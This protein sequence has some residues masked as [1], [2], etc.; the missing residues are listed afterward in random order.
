ML[1]HTPPVIINYLYQFPAVVATAV[2]WFT[3]VFYLF[4]FSS[5]HEVNA[6]LCYWVENPPPPGIV[7]HSILSIVLALGGLTPL[8]GHSRWLAYGHTFAVLVPSYIRKKMLLIEGEECGPLIIP[9]R[10]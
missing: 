6:G 3:Y 8:H 4:L 7:A 9:G 10:G 2:Q 5:F 1:R